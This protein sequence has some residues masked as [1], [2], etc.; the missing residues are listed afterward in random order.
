MSK[1]KKI[2]ILYIITTCEVGGAQEY[3]YSFLKEIKKSGD[4]ELNLA[5][6]TEGQYY[7][8]FLEVFDSIYGIKEL[9]R[10]FTLFSDLTAIIKI[11]KIIKN[12]NFDLIHIQTSKASFLGAVA[13]KLAGS[14]NIVYSAHGFNSAHATMNLLSDKFYLYLKNFIIKNSSFIAVA[15]KTVKDFIINNIKKIDN[16]KIEVI[17]TGVNFKKFS[18]IRRNSEKIH[19]KQFIIGSCGRLIKIKGH[20]FLIRSAKLVIEQCDNIDFVIYGE[21]PL[22]KYL[23]NL[24]IELNIEKNFIIKDFTENISEEMI[25]FDIYVQPAFVDSFPLAPCEAMAMG[26]PV[27]ATKVGGFPEMVTH[28]MNGYL[29]DFNDYNDLKE[30]ILDLIN[31]RDKRKEFGVNAHEYAIKNF[32]WSIV[33]KKYEDIYKNILTKE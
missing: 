4:Y 32:N 30:K 1:V 18:Y 28:G 29:V 25:N 14:R 26:I 10:K 17:Y 31:N 5:C 19:N 3:L 27:I 22:K 8:K 12:N 6:N 33:A 16:K 11:Y 7:S 9:K 20:E 15:S 24:I 21:G 23:N 2:K 13:S